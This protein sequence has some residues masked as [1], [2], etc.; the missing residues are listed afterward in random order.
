M[1]LE[2]ATDS[3]SNLL[4]FP[5][6][7]VEKVCRTEEGDGPAALETDRWTFLKSAYL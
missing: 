4:K 7:F 2:V 6:H 5:R 3:Q 1:E